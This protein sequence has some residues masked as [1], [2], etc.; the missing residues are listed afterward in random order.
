MKEL[1]ECKGQHSLLTLAN[2]IRNQRGSL[3]QTRM[4]WCKM[5]VVFKLRSC[6]LEKNHLSHEDFCGGVIVICVGV[7]TGACV[8]GA[9]D[10]I[11]LYTYFS[12]PGFSSLSLPLPPMTPDALTPQA[13]SG[14]CLSCSLFFMF[15][16]IGTLLYPPPLGHS[17]LSPLQ[18]LKFY[19]HSCFF[20]L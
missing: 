2:R 10:S 17:P 13:A 11:A 5:S 3:K 20:P 15:L 19:I 4:V 16:T 9:G 18:L 7:C 1:E 12:F 6:A 8:L 14:F